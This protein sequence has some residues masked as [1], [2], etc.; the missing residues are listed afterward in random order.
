[1]SQSLRIIWSYK[2]EDC[3]PSYTNLTQ[4]LE[5]TFPTQQMWRF[6]HYNFVIM[7]QSDIS[8]ILYVWVCHS[9]WPLQPY[10]WK[11][12]QWCQ[13]GV[14]IKVGETFTDTSCLLKQQ[15]IFSIIRSASAARSSLV[16]K[17]LCYKSEGCRITSWWGQ[18]FL[19]Y[20]ILP[21]PLWPWGRLRV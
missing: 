19:I 4:L 16:V 9:P 18:F 5:S 8:F 21:A 2:P 17:A 20:L 10:M 7:N 12:A 11:Q 14:G 13:A 15:K 6:Y 1:M 3:N